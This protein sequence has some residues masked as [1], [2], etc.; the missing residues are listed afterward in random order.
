MACTVAICSAVGSAIRAANDPAKQGVKRAVSHCSASGTTR[1][2]STVR[3]ASVSTASLVA[4][5]TLLPAVVEMKSGTVLFTA[6]QYRP[7][8][9][10]SSDDTT[11]RIAL[12][13]VPL[14]DWVASCAISGV[15]DPD[16]SCGESWW[17]RSFS[18]TTPAGGAAAALLAVS[19]S[20]SRTAQPVTNNE[21][22]C[23]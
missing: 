16:D 6:W 1:D 17:H 2:K 5:V 8:V 11:N 14:Y 12:R 4:H 9:V 13:V 23:R 3:F 10:R 15:E 21:H 7:D 22:C 20:A 18:T 19:S